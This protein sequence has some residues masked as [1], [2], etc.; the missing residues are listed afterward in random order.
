MNNNRPP[1][2]FQPQGRSMHPFI[3]PGDQVTVIPYSGPGEMEIR[4]GDCVIFRDQEQRWLIH[5]VIG[6]GE[7]SG[8]FLIK[9]DALLQPD[10]PV[11]KTSIA[12]VVTEVKRSG[13]GRIYRLDRPSARF[14][15][16]LIAGLSRLEAA[17]FSF[18]RPPR[19]GGGPKIFVRL[20][21]LPRWLLIRAFFP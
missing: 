10:P 19:V 20:I 11:M 8:R 6:F 5:R 9:G 13:S 21:K 3:R 4:P 16:R 15:T 17:V 2:S 12:G 7:G 1:I 14:L 18:N